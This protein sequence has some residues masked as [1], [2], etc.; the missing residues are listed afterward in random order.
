MIRP[1]KLPGKHQ[2]VAVQSCFAH[3]NQQTRTITA[4]YETYQTV[5]RGWRQSST[6]VTGFTG[7]SSQFIFSQPLLID[8]RL[9]PECIAKLF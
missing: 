6:M 9:T 2:S 5:A 3:P 8:V 4:R 1:K 7:R